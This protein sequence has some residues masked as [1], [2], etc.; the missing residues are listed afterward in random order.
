[1]ST[2]KG[3]PDIIKN[4]LVFYLDAANSR[5]YPGSGT[6]WNDLS[7]G[8]NNGTLINGPTFNSANGGSIVFDGV[9]DY[10]QVNNNTLLNS[11]S[12][13][14]NIWFKYINII[15]ASSTA[16]ILLGKT[17][18]G[19]SFNGYNLI[20]SPNGSIFSQIKGINNTI[21]T[22]TTFSPI[23]PTNVWCNATLTY[24]SGV[25]HALYVNSVVY[26][27][28]GCVSFTMSSQPL[29]IVDSVDTFWGIMSGNI[30]MIQIYNRVLSATEV[31]Q[32]YNATKSRYGL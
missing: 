17:D 10:G 29:R 7:R 20:I 3:G 22:Q 19:G 1:M 26:S 27:T 21:L 9:N 13:T 14:I 30:A 23:Y 31:L 16:S 4:G 2:Q 28:G 6:A 5:S 32:N 11:A 25:S 15:P 8:R 12:G 18:V 24:S